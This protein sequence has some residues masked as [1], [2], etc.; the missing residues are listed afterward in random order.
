MNDWRRVAMQVHQPTQDLPSPTLQHLS[1]NV[2]VALAIPARIAPTV[3]N[4]IR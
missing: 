2:L 4:I 3:N 1:I